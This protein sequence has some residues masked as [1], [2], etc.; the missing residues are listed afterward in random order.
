MVHQILY[1]VVVTLSTVGY[2]DITMHS[3][4]AKGC[5]IILVCLAIVVIPNQTNEVGAADD[6]S[7]D[8]CPCR[9]PTLAT[10]ST[11]PPT[12]ST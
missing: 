11:R 3:L 12:A 8:S 1:F 10:C 6:S 9:V 2:G 7:S 4:L 5:V